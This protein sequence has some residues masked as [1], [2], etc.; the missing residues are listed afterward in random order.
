MG[1][2]CFICDKS[3]NF[4]EINISGV[5]KNY[6]ICADC[7]KFL[8]IIKP[9]IVSGEIHCEIKVP[10]QQW[11]NKIKNLYNEFVEILRKKKEKKND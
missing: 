4:R 6:Y 8:D 11:D 5:D 3:T 1:K 7:V 9:K 2:R 10:L